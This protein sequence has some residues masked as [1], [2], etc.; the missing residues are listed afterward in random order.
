MCACVCTCWANTSFRQKIIQPSNNR[1]CVIPSWWLWLKAI[2]EALN[3]HIIHEWPH[4]STLGVCSKTVPLLVAPLSDVFCLLCE[5]WWRY[6]TDT[7]PLLLNSRSQMTARCSTVRVRFKALEPGLKPP[8]ERRQHVDTH[9]AYF[10]HGSTVKDLYK[11]PNSPAEMEGRARQQAWT[12]LMAVMSTQL[13][14]N[15]FL[16]L[17]KEGEKK[18]RKNNR[19]QFCLP[20]FQYVFS[21]MCH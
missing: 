21:P 2:Q 11:C 3:T 18:N 19:C 6:R 5:N 4:F 16:F 8:R 20:S 15:A 13:I 17:Q 1:K 7:E 12:R 9:R 14:H 10:F